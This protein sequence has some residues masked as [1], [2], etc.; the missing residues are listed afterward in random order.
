MK[1]FITLIAAITMIATML[2][3]CEVDAPTADDM[4]KKYDTETSVSADTDKK[5]TVDDKKDEE[6]DDK[7]ADKKD[8]TKYDTANKKKNAD[9]A[10]DTSKTADKNTSNSSNASKN[11]GSNASTGNNAS[12]SVTTQEKQPAKPAHTHSYTATVT[13][14]P[15]CGSAGVKTYT[16][17][18]S[19]SYT[20]SIPATGHNFVAQYEDR[21]KEIWHEGETQHKI[22]CTC[23]MVFNTSNEH[24]QHAFKKALAGEV[25]G[26]SAGPYDVQGQGWTE[27]ATEHVCIGNKCTICGAWQ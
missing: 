8:E 22:A 1:K 26:H 14:N 19:A 5:E 12:Q 9:K 15:T 7:D 25:N 3:G 20:E 2:T 11:S 16:C 27:Y 21:T 18:C 10:A 6:S 4:F 24:N 13:A 23:G 17:S